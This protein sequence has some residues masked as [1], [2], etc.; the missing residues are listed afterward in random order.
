M[1]RILS[2]AADTLGYRLRKLA[3]D[4][5]APAKLTGG[6]V[7]ERPRE[8]GGSDGSAGGGADEAWLRAHCAEALEAYKRPRRYRWVEAGELPLTT[9]GKVR[10]LGMKAL[11]A[12]DA[13]GGPRL[14]REGASAGRGEGCA[15]G[16]A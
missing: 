16:S 7:V 8:P 4:R 11:F 2:P 12:A 5:K 9:T 15:A 6:E 3:G 10:K 13:G 1:T 14:P